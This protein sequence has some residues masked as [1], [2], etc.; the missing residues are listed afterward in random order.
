MTIANAEMQLS[1][2]IVKLLSKIEI[3]SITCDI[4]IVRVPQDFTDF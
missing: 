1:S 3:L 4:A 2:Q